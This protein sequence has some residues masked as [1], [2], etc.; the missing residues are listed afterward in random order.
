M[1]GFEWDPVFVVSDGAL[2][3]KTVAAVGRFKEFGVCSRPIAFV[4]SW[5]AN[6]AVKFLGVKTM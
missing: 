2:M 5:R 3:F 6:L 1:G 4:I